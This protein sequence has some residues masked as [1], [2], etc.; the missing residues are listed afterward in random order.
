MCSLEGRLGKPAEG[1]GGGLGLTFL[2]ACLF[3]EEEGACTART[4]AVFTGGS[5]QK[6]AALEHKRQCSRTGRLCFGQNNKRPAF[7]CGL[8]AAGLPACP[9]PC[10]PPAGVVEASSSAPARFRFLA[11][12]SGAGA[13][14]AFRSS[15]SIKH[16]L[17]VHYDVDACN[18]C[19]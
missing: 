1:V 18:T 17:S 19:G 11:D 15:W 4:T 8:T 3:A 5:D 12:A 10:P 14:R 16:G 6:G 9:W 2:E 13:G 7:P